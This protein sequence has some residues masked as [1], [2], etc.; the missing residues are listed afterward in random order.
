MEKVEEAL[1][2]EALSMTGGNQ[3]RAAKLLF[4]SRDS[5]R[6]RMKKFGIDRF[7]GNAF[8]ERFARSSSREAIAPHD[9]DRVNAA[10]QISGQ[11]LSQDRRGF[12]RKSVCFPACI[13]ETRST[14]GEFATGTILD[15]S[16]GGIRF[17]VPKGAKLQIEASQGGNEFIISFSL[18]NNNWPIGVKCRPKRVDPLSDEIHV[19]AAFVDTDLRS[20]HALQQYLN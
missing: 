8:E 17:S 4:I 19:G 5:L 16:I 7:R 15:I 3:T 11:A 18:P 1:I 2:R 13:G 12:E 10:E 6:H 20:Y 9:R 14:C